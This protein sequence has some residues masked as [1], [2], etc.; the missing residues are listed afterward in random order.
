MNKSIDFL[1][2]TH[3][4]KNYIE[5]LLNNIINLQNFDNKKHKIIILDDNSNDNTVELISNFFKNYKIQNYKL[6]NITKK[7]GVFYNRVFL[8]ENS[9]SDYAFFIDDDD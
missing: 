7:Y 9:D 8:L 2:L 6:I 4:S 3:N 1:I 5:K